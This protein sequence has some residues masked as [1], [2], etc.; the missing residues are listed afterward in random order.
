MASRGEVIKHVLLLI[1]QEARII[2]DGGRTSLLPYET[3][4]IC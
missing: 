1:R 3:A 4:D 2:F